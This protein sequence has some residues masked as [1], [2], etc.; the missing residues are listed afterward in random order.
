MGV[1]STLRL[2]VIGPDL[3]HGI[4]ARGQLELLLQL[5]SEMG[6]RPMLCAPHKHSRP[7]AQAPFPVFQF[8]ILLHFDAWMKT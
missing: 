5:H 4:V 7:V 3:D 2:H 8:N 6:S 1:Q